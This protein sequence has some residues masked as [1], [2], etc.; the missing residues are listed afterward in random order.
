MSAFKSVEY[1]Y[2]PQCGAKTREQIIE[3]QAVRV[4]AAKCGFGF[5]NNPTPV[6][7]VIVETPEGVVLASDVTWPKG[8]LSVITGYVDP[9]ELPEQTALRETKEELG[10]NPYDPVFVG[11]Y[12]FHAKN[13]L[14]MAYAVKA[15]GRITLNH[16]L[17]E[18]KVIPLNKLKAWPGPTG[19]AVADWL[20]QKKRA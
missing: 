4:C 17:D 6:V 10:L 5:F 20:R 19:E 8:V 15:Q 16:E 3:G 1:H 12:M 2:C 18:Y 11:H 13:Q 9:H 14:I 7:A